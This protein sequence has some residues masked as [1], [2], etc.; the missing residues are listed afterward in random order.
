MIFFLVSIQLKFIYILIV[1]IC[2]Y[3]VN[4]FSRKNFNEPTSV[5]CIG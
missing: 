5:E 4:I 3:G 2:T 1:F